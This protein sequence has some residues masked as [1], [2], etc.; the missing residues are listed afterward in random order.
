[1]TVYPTVSLVAACH[2][3]LTTSKKETDKSFGKRLTDEYAK[4]LLAP[5]DW[6]S[7]WRLNCNIVALHSLFNHEQTKD[8]YAM[9]N[10][11]TFL[12]EGS[13]RGVPVSPFLKTPALVIKHKNEE[14][15][16]GIFFYKN[17]LEGGDWILQE[18]IHNSEWVNSLLPESAP[19]STF[20]VITCSKASVMT[21]E[22]ESLPPR[23]DCVKALSCVFRAGR[24]N[25]Q[26]DHD[27]ILFDVDVKTGVIGR[28]TVNANWYKLGASAIL[29]TP[30][31]SRSKNDYHEHPDA[32]GVMVSGNHVPGLQDMLH[33]VEQAHYDMTPH[34]PFAGWDVVLSAD[35]KVPV[36]L[37]E[38]NLS[39]N[40]FRGSFDQQYYLDS[41]EAF[42]E[43]LQ[44]QRLALDAE[45]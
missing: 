41:I 28:G 29:S 23:K 4:R 38:V 21:E 22:G 15:G 13:D 34:V 6:F 25:A 39:C 14:G 7:Y 2:Y 12:K 11:W 19:L 1:M 17:A 31:R 3:A 44:A 32:D 36:C 24:K 18:R 37:L 9:E 40:F 20:R 27:S 26:T 10:K 8:Q 42:M 5:D 16:M 43:K 45:S 30:W 35:K 33:L